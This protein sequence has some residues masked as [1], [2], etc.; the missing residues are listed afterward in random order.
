MSVG[1]YSDPFLSHF[2]HAPSRRPPLINRGYYTRVAAIHS[3]LLSFIRLSLPSSADKQIVSFGAGSDTLYFRLKADGHR[4]TR[5]VEVD[6]P[7]AIDRKRRIVDRREQLTRLAGGEG[8]DAGDGVVLYDD[9]ALVSADLRDV[10]QLEERLG[11]ARVSWDV[12]TFFL[13]ECVLVYL[14]AAEASAVIRWTASRFTGGCVFLAYEQLH[15]DTAFGRT[16]VSNLQARGC[17]LL[18]LPAYP[19]LASQRHRYLVECGYDAYAGWDMLDVHSAYLD[20]EDVRRA[21]RVEGLDE[22]EE[23]NLIQSHYHISMA[24]KRRRRARDEEVRTPTEPDPEDALLMTVGLLGAKKLDKTRAKPGTST[25]EYGRA[26]P[27]ASKQSLKRA[28]LVSSTR[29]A[30]LVTASPALSPSDGSA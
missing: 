8:R 9:Y 11:R 17:P 22:L 15:P 26:G 27:F 7:D 12:P 30:P 10:Q 5:Y 14:P 2:I 21:E 25:G 1:Y 19:D 16:M 28:D 3:A 29:Y 6:F 23:W 18:S 13:S 4:V 24:A 20:Q